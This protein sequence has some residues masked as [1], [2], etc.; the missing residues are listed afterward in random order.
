MKRQ[1]NACGAKALAGE[2]LEQGNFLQ[3]RDW[4]KKDNKTV[5][6][7]YNGEVLQKSRVR[8]ILKHGSVRGLIHSV[9]I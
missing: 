8:E 5:S 6:K 4:I 7:T 9:P 3:T 1:G 2:L